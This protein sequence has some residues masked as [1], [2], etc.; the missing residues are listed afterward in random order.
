[1][2]E[3]VL[4]TGCAGFIGSNL[5]EDLLERGYDVVGID[6]L[7]TDREENLDGLEHVELS[8]DVAYGK[9][10]H[11]IGFDIDEERVRALVAV[12]HAAFEGTGLNSDYRI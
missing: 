2:Q 4:V 8:L 5:I 3:R 12:R 6:D 7:S 10:G 11:V 9:K 1:M